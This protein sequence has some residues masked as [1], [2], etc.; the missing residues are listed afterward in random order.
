MPGVAPVK[1]AGNAIADLLLGTLST[2]NRMFKEHFEDA[3]IQ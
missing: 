2:F 1:N 3:L